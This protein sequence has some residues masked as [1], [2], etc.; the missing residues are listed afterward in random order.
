M[1]PRGHVQRA[2][3]NYFCDLM[4]QIEWD[5]HQK[6]LDEKCIPYE[7]NRIA[8]DRPRLGK[9]RLT[10]RVEEDLVELCP[11]VGDGMIRRLG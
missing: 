6:V 10:L 3:M 4:S 8:R 1:A 7:W 2:H 5:L 9:V 11:K